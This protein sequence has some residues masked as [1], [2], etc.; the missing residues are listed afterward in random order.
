MLSL[1]GL[2]TKANDSFNSSGV[3][4]VDDDTLNKTFTE[5][6]GTPPWYLLA[7]SSRARTDRKSVSPT[8]KATGSL[9]PQPSEKTPEKT[10]PDFQLVKGLRAPDLE[11][12]IAKAVAAYSE[13]ACG[14]QQLQAWPV[15]TPLAFQPKQRPRAEPCVESSTSIVAPASIKLPLDPPPS[16]KLP[17]DL[18]KAGSGRFGN[19][20]PS[21]KLPSDLHN[22]GSARFGI[23]NKPMNFSPP[24]LPQ[25]TSNHPEALTP[26]RSRG[27][28]DQK[29]WQSTSPRGVAQVL[30]QPRPVSVLSGSL[31][32][33]SRAR[34]VERSTKP[35]AFGP[36]SAR[37]ASA[38]MHQEI[39]VPQGP[40][41]RPG[42]KRSSSLSYLSARPSSQVS[43]TCPTVLTP[44]SVSLSLN[45]SLSSSSLT[46]SLPISRQVSQACRNHQD[47][48]HAAPDNS[49]HEKLSGWRFRTDSTSAGST[50][51]NGRSEKR[52]GDVTFQDADTAMVR[53]SMGSLRCSTTTFRSVSAPSHSR[54]DCHL[55]TVPRPV[56]SAMPLPRF[57]S[58]TVP[59]NSGEDNTLLSWPRVPSYKHQH[60]SPR[61]IPAVIVATVED[62][63]PS[64][65]ILDYEME[66]F[67][68]FLDPA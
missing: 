52:L 49:Y 54:S 56:T 48:G 45:K 26:R 58:S 27:K 47:L 10:E 14:P 20:P 18:Y 16:I 41:I 21:I 8:R 15:C 43:S 4:S 65:K 17:L 31:D 1:F 62:S 22:D 24:P 57:V 6:E 35:L 25:F 23:G 42:P 32:S 59:C 39:V 46:N 29:F 36:E 44:R 53:S 34:S 60:G 3:Q 37:Q 40:M 11:A 64:A 51:V 28:P 9:P 2:E 66:N 33:R 67:A 38:R 55:T 30:P 7:E 19:P 63:A 5:K 12:D 50:T 61:V 13:A 68:G